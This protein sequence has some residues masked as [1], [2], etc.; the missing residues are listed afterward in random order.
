VAVSLGC[1]RFLLVVFCFG[2]LLI[3]VFGGLIKGEVTYFVAPLW[4]TQCKK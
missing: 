1:V 2:L 4:R 3:F